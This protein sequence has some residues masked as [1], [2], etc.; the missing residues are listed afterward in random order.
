MTIQSKKEK[1]VALLKSIE[2][3]DPAPVAFINRERYIQ[4]NLQVEDGLEGFG[5]LLSQLPEG[6][7]KVDVIRVFEDGDFV[8]THTRYNFFGPKAGFDIFRFENG[9]IVEHWDN[10]QDIVEQ[11]LSGRSQFDGPTEVSDTEKTAANKALVKNFV[12]DVLLGKNPSKIDVYISS[13]KY[14]QHNPHV[15]DGLDGLLK[16]IHE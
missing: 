1:A 3:G 16:A 4:H 9:L 6:S 11:S 14:L 2:T 12:E 13:R 8:F 10:L 7:A 15:A 5:K